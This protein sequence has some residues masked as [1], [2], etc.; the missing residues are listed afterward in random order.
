MGASFRYASID[1]LDMSWL[2]LSRFESRALGEQG[3][4]CAVAVYG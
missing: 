2:P 1:S 4:V 3:A